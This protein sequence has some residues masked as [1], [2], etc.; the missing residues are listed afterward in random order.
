MVPTDTPLC[1]IE[2]L[3]TDRSVDFAA[4]PDVAQARLPQMLTDLERVITL[5]LSLIH[6]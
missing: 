5:E 2:D 4:L 6:I 3:M 1:G